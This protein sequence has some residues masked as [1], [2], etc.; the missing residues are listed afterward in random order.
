MKHHN[1]KYIFYICIHNIMMYIYIHYKDVHCTWRRSIQQCFPKLSLLHLCNDE[2]V[3]LPTAANQTHP[4]RSFEVQTCRQPSISLETFHMQDLSST[5]DGW[6]VWIWLEL[7]TRAQDF[8]KSKGNIKH[9]EIRQVLAA[10]S[11]PEGSLHLA[12]HCRRKHSNCRSDSLKS[13]RRI[14]YMVTGLWVVN[15]Q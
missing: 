2:P 11:S 6:H 5:G 14:K 9:A 13:L 15:A 3:W 1:N 10:V 12:L 8:R 7:L 4:E